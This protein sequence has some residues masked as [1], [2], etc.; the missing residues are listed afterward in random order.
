ML[1]GRL[2]VSGQEPEFGAAKVHINLFILSV[3]HLPLYSE[4]RI[5]RSL[6][7]S[8]PP[9]KNLNSFSTINVWR[10]RWSG[11][12]LELKPTAQQRLGVLQVFCFVIRLLF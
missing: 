7:P 10:S 2:L 8:L 11:G 12:K 1:L 6:S 4:N 9:L 5:L 3:L